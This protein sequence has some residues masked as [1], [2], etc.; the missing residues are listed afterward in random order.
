MNI[1]SDI[2]VGYDALSSHLAL[3][4]MP[5]RDSEPTGQARM[6]LAWTCISLIGLPGPSCM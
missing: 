1:K 2:L 6:T 4:A 5:C 3:H